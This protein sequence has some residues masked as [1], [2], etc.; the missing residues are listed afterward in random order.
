[1]MILKK[2][3]TTFQTARRAIR[4][5]GFISLYDGLSAQVFRQCSYGLLRFHLYHKGKEYVD[6]FNFLHKIFVATVAGTIAGI[7]GIPSEMI[8]TRM[9][10]DRMLSPKIQRN[11]KHVFHGFYKV[12]REEGI[13]ALYTGGMYACTR[14]ALATVGQIAVYDQSKI[15]YLRYLKLDEDSKLLHL[16]SSLSAGIICAPLVQPIEILKTLKMVATSNYLS[17]K[18]QKKI[19]LMRF[20]FRGLFRGFTAT[21]CRMVPNTIILMLVYEELRLRFGYY[22][23]HDL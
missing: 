13:R 10:I 3:R 12:C 21:I 14:S 6:E 2:D 16:I 17:T 4:H 23:P 5:N 9:Q 15:L 22:Q 19:H 7:V 8:N 20:G 1:M 11:Y 18:K